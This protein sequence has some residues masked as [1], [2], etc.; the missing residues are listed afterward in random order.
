MLKGK[1][2][3]GWEGGNLRSLDQQKSYKTP[4]EERLVRKRRRKYP[5][6]NKMIIKIRI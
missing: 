2:G 1:E 6:K 4:V 5:S 3:E